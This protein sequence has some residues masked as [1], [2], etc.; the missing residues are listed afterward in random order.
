MSETWLLRD[1]NLSVPFGAGQR[2][3]IPGI[4]TSIAGKTPFEYRAAFMP[5]NA[6][7]VRM[8]Q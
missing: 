5:M 1:R 8:G 7:I 3:G 6:A 2:A 4:E